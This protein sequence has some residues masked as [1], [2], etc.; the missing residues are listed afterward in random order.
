MRDS[1]DLKNKTIKRIQ[2]VQRHKYWATSIARWT[3][4]SYNT[5]RHTVRHAVHKCLPHDPS[6]FSPRGLPVAPDLVFRTWVPSR[7]HCSQ[8]F[9]T[10]HTERSTCPATRRVDQPAVFIQMIRPLSN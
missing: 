7:L 3:T 1:L 10:A 5:C 2:G 4:S 8:Q 9:L 6:I